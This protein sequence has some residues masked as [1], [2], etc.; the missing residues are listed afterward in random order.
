M[1]D[2]LLR[3][4]T[5]LRAIKP[6]ASK[7]SAAD[8][9]KALVANGFAVTRRSIER[10][11]IKLAQIFPLEHDATKPRGWWWKKSAD[12]FDLPAM[13]LHTAL[14]FRMAGE[15]LAWLL[16]EATRARLQ[17]HIDRAAKV[18]QELPDNGLGAWPGKVR[19]LPAGPA[20]L[21]PAIDRE[22]LERVQAGVLHEKRLHI[23][24]CPR[25]AAQPRTY[26]VHPHALVWRGAVGHLV[27]SFGDHE[28]I[29]YLPL[30]RLQAVQVEEAAK[31]TPVG[32]NLDAEI[33][34]GLM[35]FVLSPHP[36]R[37]VVAMPEFAAIKLRETPL[38]AD[39]TVADRPD[40]RV[41]IAATVPDTVQ[42]RT[43]LLGFGKNLEVLEP[44]ALREEIAEHAA[45][46]ARLYLP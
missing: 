41:Q 14:A 27:C 23:E 13:D 39:Q 17:P 6:H 10:D 44:A 12:V 26:H 16:P 31:R 37:L 28:D 4:W 2:T 24:Y 40:G 45:A 35:E 22:L 11:L 3:H 42:L 9:E 5:M 8:V 1:N 18:L 43:L 19:V 36:V 25:G 32:L 30:H 29:A 33:R 38:S 21:P 7:T 20:L 46:M 15:H 34:A